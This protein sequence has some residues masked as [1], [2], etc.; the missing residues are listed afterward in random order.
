MIRAGIRVLDAELTLQNNIVAENGLYAVIND[1]TS[2]LQITGN[3][4]GTADL[5]L[6][7]TLVRDGQDRAG[8]GLVSIQQP[9]ISP[10][11]WVE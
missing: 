3:W 4:W 5:K 9:L 10:P 8:L 6:L 11:A 2:D 1:G 7:S